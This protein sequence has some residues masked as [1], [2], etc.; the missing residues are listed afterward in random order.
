M[1]LPTSKTSIR[2]RL[3]LASAA[4]QIVLLSILLFNSMRLMDS[5]TEASVDVLIEQNASILHALTTAY[6][7]QNAYQALQD[8]L[9]ELLVD[10]HEGLVYVRVLREDGSELINSGAPPPDSAFPVAINGLLHSASEG[11]QTLHSYRSLLLQNNEVGQLQFG[12]ATTTLA[13]TRQSI[14]TQG[15]ALVITSIMITTLL[16]WLIGQL[17]MRNLDKLLDGSRALA[18]GQLAHRIAHSGEDEFTDLADRF[19]LMADRLQ[20]RIVELAQTTA[21]LEKSE[22]RYA[23][24]VKGAND[25]LWDWDITRRSVHVTSRFC[26]IFGLPQGI[27]EL[28]Q[29]EIPKRMRPE[30]VA[31]GYQQLISHLKGEHEQFKIEIEIAHPDGTYRWVLVRGVALRGD[32][33]HASR[34]AGSISDIQQQK[35]AEQQLLHDA[36]HDRVTKLANRALLLEH[37]RYAIG[38]RRRDKAFHFAL[39]TFDLERF[40]AINDSFGH[41]EGDRV[42]CEVAERIRRFVLGGDIAARVG[43]DQ[44]AVLITDIDD[45][46]QG[47]RLAEA[48][49]ET[50]C[51]P[52]SVKG[53]QL[54]Y[55]KVHIGIALPENEECTP[56]SLLR[57]SDN[58]LHDGKRSGQEAI[59]IYHAS[60]HARAI[61]SLRLESDLRE[62]LNQSLIDVHLQPIVSLMDKQVRSYEALA[63]W[64][65]PSEGNIPPCNFI[66]VA[67]ARG[68]V[69]QLG[70]IMLDKVCH[71]IRGWQDTTANGRVPRISVNLSAIQ[72]NTPN[73]AKELVDRVRAS[74]VPATLLSFEIT[75][76]LLAESEGKA[77]ETLASLRQAGHRVLIDDFGTGYSA[78][79]YLH[80]IPCDIIKF[81]G[82]FI[83]SIES[84]M[85]LQAIVRRTVQLAHDLGIEVVAEW[86]E[87][88]GQAEI[89]RDMGC[90]YGQGYLFGKPVAVKDVPTTWETD[91][92]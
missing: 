37:L 25:G 50:I 39:I 84:D 78:L 48:L 20:A 79:A 11:A 66:P 19:N 26:E 1:R 38:H 9:D 10:A 73:L 16:L 21:H 35:L 58:A 43:G 6:G 4:V 24:S 53:G 13:N 92:S 27:T 41:D 88:E 14:L 91:N 90:E 75:E 40:H 17:L 44:F 74:G 36:F 18:A 76:S 70:L 15:T 80:N 8:V 81:D 83:R 77:L 3:L 42:L 68:L 61:Q 29:E 87:N 62:A 12:V 22:E 47:P 32:S 85:R 72:L 64:H 59:R 31:T 2:S 34:M 28:N 65:H 57:D 67:E 23:L 63:R 52:I 69:H 45:E 49:R 51:A 7:E 55:P 71:T 46:S 5:A 60:M 86:V 33:G 56:E 30:N 54:I 89:L 82:K